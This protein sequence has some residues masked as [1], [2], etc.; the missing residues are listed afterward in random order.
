M[1]VLDFA[2]A[3]LVVLGVKETEALVDNRMGMDDTGWGDVGTDRLA[4]SE[5]GL[6]ITGSM[7][8]PQTQPHSCLWWFGMGWGWLCPISWGL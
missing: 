1:N 7:K 5:A 8:P 4:G 2:V 3:I 6:G